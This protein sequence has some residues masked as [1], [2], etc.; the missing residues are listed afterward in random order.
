MADSLVTD[1]TL[2]ALEKALDISTQRHTL[3]ANNIANVDTIG[4]KPKDLDFKK[5]LRKAL[6]SNSINLHQTH[7]QHIQVGSGATGQRQDAGTVKELQRRPDVDK[8]MAHLIENNIK[9][10]TS[11][12]ML[13]RK[14]NMIR[15]A[16]AEGGR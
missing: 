1:S 5:T 11:V 9:F 10:R 4:Y 8:E 6:N 12:E 15:H 14:M 3:I 7:P 13:L 16:I 2:N